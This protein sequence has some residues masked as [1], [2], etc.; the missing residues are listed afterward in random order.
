MPM[1]LNIMKTKVESMTK[2]HQIEVLKIITSNS[3]LTINENKSGVYINLSYMEQT[4][5]EEIEKYL[6]FVEEQE[7]LLNT[8]ETTKQDFKNTFF[9]NNT[10]DDATCL[11][12]DAILTVYR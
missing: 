12:D 6:S 10:D 1:D 2:V 7:Q 3:N 8:A 11:N 9:N 4:V 5:I